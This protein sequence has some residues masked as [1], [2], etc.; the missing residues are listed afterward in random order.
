MQREIR[1]LQ[2]STAL[3]IKLRFLSVL[4]ARLRKNLEMGFASL[5]ALLGHYKNMQ[6]R[7]SFFCSKTATSALSMRSEL[8]LASTTCELLDVFVVIMSRALE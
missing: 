2:Q 3:I 7:Y 1:K 8:P 6:K 4:F 5:E